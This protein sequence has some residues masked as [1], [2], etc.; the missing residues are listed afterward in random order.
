[1]LKSDARGQQPNSGDVERGTCTLNPCFLDLLGLATPAVLGWGLC[2]FSLGF[3]MTLVSFEENIQIYCQNSWEFGTLFNP[4]L[5]LVVSYCK[6]FGKPCVD[7]ERNCR[8]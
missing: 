6:P 1:M 2:E 3:I 8:R 4:K 5:G 7:L